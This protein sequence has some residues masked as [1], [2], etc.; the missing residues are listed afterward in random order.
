VKLKLADEPPSQIL[1]FY[2]VPTEINVSTFLEPYYSDGGLLFTSIGIIVHTIIF[3][4]LALFFLQYP[5]RL[6]LVGLASLCYCNFMGFFT[7]AFTNF[8]TWVFL[9]LA[10]G[11]AWV[12]RAKE[13]HQSAGFVN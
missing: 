7:P 8:P 12:A 1:D 9:L 2:S 13:R 10:L 6:S 3:N 5:T 11:S 4:F